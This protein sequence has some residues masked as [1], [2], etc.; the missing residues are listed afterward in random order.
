MNYSLAKFNE[1]FYFRSPVPDEN[2]KTKL[3]KKKNISQNEG[4]KIISAIY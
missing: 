2:G 3:N 1:Q 4:N